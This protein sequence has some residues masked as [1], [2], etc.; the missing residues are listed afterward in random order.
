M[1]KFWKWAAAIFVSLVCGVLAVFSFQGW[2]APANNT[3]KVI[4][5]VLAVQKFLVG[6]LGNTFSGLVFSAFAVGI[7]VLAW[8]EPKRPD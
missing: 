4:A 8:R 6:A 1:D 7:L 2:E 5:M 3:N